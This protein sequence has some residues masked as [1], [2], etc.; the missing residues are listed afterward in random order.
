[1]EN[2]II[3]F[4]GQD[5]KLEVNL[6]NE[7][8][9]LNREQMAKLFKVDRTGISRHINNIY[10]ENE[11]DKSSTCAKFAHVGND[12]NQKYETDFYN[13]DMI[14]SVGFRVKSKNG[15]IFRRWANETINNYLLK[16]YAINQKRLDF[17]KKQ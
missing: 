16:G 2:E 4:K 1:M 14:I 11:L 10:K 17:L 15:I 8:V 9:W 7:T 13:L 5:V 3:L 12:K 6:Q